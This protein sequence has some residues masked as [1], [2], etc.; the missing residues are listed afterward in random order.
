MPSNRTLS[1]RFPYLHILG[2]AW[3]A[4]LVSGASSC[5]LFE[6]EDS[7]APTPTITAPVT[8][9]AEST[10][11]TDSSPAT[12]TTLPPTTTTSSVPESTTTTSPVRVALDY[13][14]QLLAAQ[15]EIARFVM[16]VRDINDDWDNRSQTGVSFS[17][18]ELALEE[19]VARAQSLQDTFVLIKAPSEFGLRDEHRVA[20]SAVGILVDSPP[21]MLDGLR[22]PDTGEARRAVLAGFLTAFDL[23]GQVIDRVAAITGE[24][25]IEM[26][27]ASRADDSFPVTTPE[28]TTT[29]SSTSAA[30]GATLGTA[31]PDPG[32]TKNCSDFSTQAEAQEWFDAYFPFYGDV[33]LLDTNENNLA[34]ELLP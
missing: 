31:P 20:S 33:A 11:T 25:G 14:E 4:L 5:A 22:S 19:T 34:C 8:I 6:P 30:T 26:L 7:L 13:L 16:E 12:S 21:Q 9:L 24:E 10:S 28:E 15:A 17:D 2:P 27:E 32:N 1:S 29:T 18:T 3:L 23:F